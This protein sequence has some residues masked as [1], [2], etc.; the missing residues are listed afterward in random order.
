MTKPKHFHKAP[1]QAPVDPLAKFEPYV[2]PV[3]IG[4][5]VLVVGMSAIALWR[6]RVDSRSANEWREFSLAYFETSNTRGPDAM[7]QF[8]ERFPATTAGLAAEQIAGDISMRNGLG[9]QIQDEAGSKKDLE[10]AR[11]KFEKVVDGSPQKSGL[12]YERAVYSLAYAN[13][14]LRNCDEAVR[15][16][17]EL[18]NNEES[19]F[20]ELARRGIERCKLAQSVGF[21]E[22]LDKFEQ[23]LSG[24]AP[25]VGLPERPDIS[26]PMPAPS[27]EFAPNEPAVP[28]GQE[29]SNDPAP[30]P[31]DSATA[32]NGNK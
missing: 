20:A 16:Y 12:M 21:F 30:A 27:G 15:R 1:V 8:S 25:G 9:K 3:L 5:G 32:P 2:K 26:Y 23:E 14:S 11:K 18:A 7:S 10:T 31:N 4:I 13:E 6:S 28:S 17:E 29:K 22:A 24:P 19:T